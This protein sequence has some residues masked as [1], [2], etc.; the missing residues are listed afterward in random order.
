M[1]N[2]ILYTLSFLI[3]SKKIRRFLKA[4]YIYKTVHPKIENYLEQ[5]YIIPYFKQ[6]FHHNL[7]PQKKF[8]DEKIIWQFWYQGLDNAPKIIQK[9]IESIQYHMKD[10]Y[11][12][13][14]LTKENLK[15]YIDFPEF[16]YSKL[17]NNTFGE[18]TITFFSDLLRVSLLSIYGGIWIDAAMFLS[19]KIQNNLLEQDFFV[20]HR[21]K[22]KP[23]DHLKWT[24]Y[25]YYYFFWDDNFKVNILNGFIISKKGHKLTNTLMNILLE[26][27]EKEANFK[28]YF[29]FQVIFD[30][31]EKKYIPIS[32][33]PS[34]DID[35]HLLQFYAKYTYNDDLWNEI[36]SKTQIHSLKNF[37]YISTNTMLQKILEL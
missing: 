29:T 4:K 12:I 31:L 35:V 10:E 22:E 23:M 19:D 16:V 1:T 27:W 2:K 20:F 26:Y 30:I 7:T 37:K 13:I 25:N 17:E 8:E 24:N 32:L 6:K 33:L 28:F 11:K 14:I 3:P 15:D 21:S 36:K 5:N 18:K 34:N 9:C